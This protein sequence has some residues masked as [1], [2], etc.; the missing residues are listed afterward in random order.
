MRGSALPDTFIVRSFYNGSTK[1]TE[2]ELMECDERGQPGDARY[3]CV[4]RM[5]DDGAWQPGEK[6]VVLSDAEKKYNECV[7]SRIATLPIA[8]AEVPDGVDGI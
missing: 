5:S 4:F 2:V 6:F 8:V 3:W 1:R 7:E